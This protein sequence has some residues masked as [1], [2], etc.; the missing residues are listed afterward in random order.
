MFDEIK[1]IHTLHLTGGEVFLAYEKLKMLLEIAKEKNVS[2][3]QCSFLT[4]GTIYDERIYSLLDDFFGDNYEVGISDD[5]YHKD[6]IKRIFGENTDKVFEN[7]KKHFWH[8]CCIGFK[9]AEN[10]LINTGRA[11]QLNVLKNEFEPI[12]YFYDLIGESCLFVG[13]IIFVGSDGYISD[14]NIEIESRPEQSLG[15]ILEENISTMVQRGAIHCRF[16]NQK[17]FLIAMS[18]RN[19][20][21]NYYRGEHYQ[22]QNHRL[23]TKENVR[24]IDYNAI[25]QDTKSIIQLHSEKG[26]NSQ[27]FKDALDASITEYP[28]DLSQGVHQHK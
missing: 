4:N 20:D 12:G 22:F 7:I 10:I 16:N 5:Y 24:N 25:I 8:R 18:K 14:G 6:S 9:N 1:F 23:V 15:N 13:P 17:E 28:F 26:I 27:E 3:K 2:I 19:Q 21:F 11:K